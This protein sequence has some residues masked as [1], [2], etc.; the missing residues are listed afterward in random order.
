[1]Y[2]LEQAS[3]CDQKRCGDASSSELSR[4]LAETRDVAGS[5]PTLVRVAA[6]SVLGDATEGAEVNVSKRLATSG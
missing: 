2:Q 1:M 5:G 6:P 3:G 4:L